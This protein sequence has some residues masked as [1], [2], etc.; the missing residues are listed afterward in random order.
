MAF[1]PSLTPLINDQS[2]IVGLRATS[3]G[4]SADLSNTY[5]RNELAI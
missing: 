4:F 3:A 2:A 5:G 1:C